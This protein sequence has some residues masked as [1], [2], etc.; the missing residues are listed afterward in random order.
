MT[1]AN[2]V[3]SFMSFKFISSISSSFNC[4]VSSQLA[5]GGVGSMSLLS[6]LSSSSATL[7]LLVF[8]SASI[9]ILCRVGLVISCGGN[10]SSCL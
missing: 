9:H 1:S 3:T 2:S 10:G 4:I 7:L 8:T 5:V 6:C